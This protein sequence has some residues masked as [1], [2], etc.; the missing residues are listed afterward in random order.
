[1]SKDKLIKIRIPL[2]FLTF[3]KTKKIYPDSPRINH[4]SITPNFK[5]VVGL[6]LKKLPKIKIK[7]PFLIQLRLLIDNI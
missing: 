3:K 6:I 5:K 4:K 1:M 2:N 7:H